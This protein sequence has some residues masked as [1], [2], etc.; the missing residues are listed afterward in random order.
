M[1]TCAAAW[2]DPFAHKLGL[3]ALTAPTLQANY[4][5]VFSLPLGPWFGFHNTVVSGSLLMGLYAAYP[6]HWLVQTI[7]A[8]IPRRAAR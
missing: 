5:T 6:V 2:T 8:V 7:C 1:F 3:F 4:A